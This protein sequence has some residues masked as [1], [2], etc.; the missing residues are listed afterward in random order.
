MGL[1]RRSFVALVVAFAGAALSRSAP[2]S[3]PP[4]EAPPPCP[5]GMVL[6][7]GA[8]CP[9]LEHVCKRWL[10]PPPYQNLRCAE[11][12]RAPSCKGA[13]EPVRYCVD[14]DER[15]EAGS[16]L[17]RV[18]VSWLEAKAACEAAGA[19]LCTEREWE[20][21][22]EGDEGRPYPY[23]FTRDS[24]ACNIDRTGLGAPGGGLKDLRAPITAYER[25]TSPYGVHDMTGNV[26]EWVLR[27]GA[28][29][30]SRSVLRGGWWLPGRNRCRAATIGH[31]EG[32]SGKQVGF[33][34]CADA[35]A[36]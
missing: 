24:S 2:A 34:C 19:R 14:R 18:S 28:P 32:Y 12:E 15:A 21:A 20:H 11:F 13:R 4:P 29:V 36:P 31:G 27:E 26:D 8:H 16:A 6:V 30:G 1:P 25:C 3:P 23:G 9:E 5:T 33:R 7:A 22:C 10:D 35:R 17:P